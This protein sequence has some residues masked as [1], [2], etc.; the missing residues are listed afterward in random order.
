MQDSPFKVK[1]Q[2]Q[3]TLREVFL[4][5]NKKHFYAGLFFLSA[6][7]VWT[8]AVK[9]C[10]L[11]AIGPKD[12][13]VGFAALNGFFHRFTGVHLWLY[14]LTDLLSIIP[15]GIAAGFGL[16]GL[17]Q[18]VGRK[19]LFKVDRDITALGAFYLCIIS[20]YLFFEKFA[21]NYRPVLIDG[22][23][24]ASYPSS[25]TVLVLCVM[26]TAAVQADIRIQKPLLR[27]AVKKSVAVF[28]VFMVVARLVC[29][30][31][32]LTDIAGGVLLSFGLVSFYLYG[33][34][35]E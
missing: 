2:E 23:L 12:S 16:M 28:S 22:V 8:M 21:V 34:K 26:L 17:C 32:W 1:L 27:T 10:D 20:A 11:Q 6:F 9:T 33:I 35:R 13:I 29:G 4:M 3:F 19:S 5:K 25:T 15:L 30:V 24:E 14:V 31:H 7:A 18:L